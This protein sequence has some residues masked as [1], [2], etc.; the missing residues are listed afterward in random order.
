[1]AHPGTPIPMPYE[2]IKKENKDQCSVVE[3]CE[4]KK[5]KNV[6]NKEEVYKS[7]VFS[8]FFLMNVLFWRLIKNAL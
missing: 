4:S 8:P 6:K 7:L 1:M 2:S 5:K 3:K